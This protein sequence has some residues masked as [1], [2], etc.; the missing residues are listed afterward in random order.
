MSGGTG[1]QVGIVLDNVRYEYPNGVVALR[2][3]SITMGKG[4]TVAIVGENGAGKT[5]L[6]KHLNGLLKPTS[7][8]VT[9]DGIDTRGRTAAS[10]ARLVGF[11]FQN[12]DDQ[13]F[14][15]QVSREVAFGP[16][17][18]GY[19]ADRVEK[20]VR[21]AVEQVEITDLLARHPY[22]LGLAQ[23]KLVAIASV[24]AMDTPYIVLDEPTTGQDYPGTEKLGRLV[25]RLGSAGKTVMAIT[26]DMEFAAE[27]FARI[28]VMAQGQVILDG[29]PREVFSHPSGLERASVEPPQLARLGQLMGLGEC[30]LNEEDLLRSLC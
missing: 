2:G 21:W 30:I 23:R 17:N 27:H 10:L 7:G 20:L 19:A 13:L 15:N 24:V 8:S 5:T 1:T 3:V 18:L 25:A 22:D 12:P 14:Q 28:I 11:V 6:A 4:E 9:V 29:S 26:H 16:R